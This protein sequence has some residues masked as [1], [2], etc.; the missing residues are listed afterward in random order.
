MNL[1][2]GG[3]GSTSVSVG[4]RQSSYKDAL[5]AVVGLVA[6]GRAIQDQQ[7]ERKTPLQRRRKDAPNTLKI[8]EA[9][10]R[11]TAADAAI[12]SPEA[13]QCSLG[14]NSRPLEKR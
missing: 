2:K 4:E 13:Q 14:V 12:E 1:D 5:G 6:V 9:A 3:R 11:S 10:G 7:A 8:L